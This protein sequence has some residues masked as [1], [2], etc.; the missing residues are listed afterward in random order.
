MMARGTDITQHVRAL[1]NAYTAWFTEKDNMAR[2]AALVSQ[3]V[4][5]N[6][7]APKAPHATLDLDNLL[8]IDL[9]KLWVNWACLWV[10]V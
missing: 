2:P 9:R 5:S 7:P 6:R 1:A 8:P 10:Q 4:S 3:H